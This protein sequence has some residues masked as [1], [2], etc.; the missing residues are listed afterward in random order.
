MIEIFQ[1]GFMQRALVAGIFIA[2]LCALFSVF[3]VLKRLSFIGVGISHSAF[4][5]VALGFLLGIN[6]T[7]TA[8]LFAGA[9]ALLI[10]F[11]NR[12]GRLHED[13]AIGIFFALNMALGI[14]FIGL[15]R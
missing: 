15:S 1:L 2:A 8:I 12:Q 9:T 7:I 5:G 4:G 10:G 6:P 14:L 3:V 11:V 13:T